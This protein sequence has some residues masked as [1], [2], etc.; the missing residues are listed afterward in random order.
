ME[1]AC[2]II[3]LVYKPF[4]L[5]NVKQVPT[6]FTRLSWRMVQKE[7]M[8][9][10]LLLLKEKY[11]RKKR[12]FQ[13]RSLHTRQA[14]TST[15]KPKVQKLW[16]TNRITWLGVDLPWLLWIWASRAFIL[17]YFLPWLLVLWQRREQSVG[18]AQE[19]ATQPAR[20]VAVSMMRHPAKWRGSVSVP[21]SS[22]TVPLHQHP[23][24]LKWTK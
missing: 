20:N 23:R 2:T 1:D 19:R 9:T 3:S 18:P 6:S 21:F 15:L 10:Y 16:S 12:R 8:D 24:Y 17:I 22:H 5:S 13:L 7:N 4:L 14:F 11:S